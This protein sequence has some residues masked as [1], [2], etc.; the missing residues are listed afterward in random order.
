[1]ILRGFWQSE[2]GFTLVE[3]MTTITILGVLA[4]VAMSSWFGVVESR[5]VDSATNEVVSEL[6]RAHTS[7]TTRLDDWQVVLDLGTDNYQV[8]PA[9]GPLSSRSLV[10]EEMEEGEPPPVVLTGEITAVEFQADGEAT[11]T[12]TGNIQVAADDGS[13]CHEI[14]VNTVTSRIEVSTNAC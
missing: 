12:G 10:R 1:V 11:I 13:P 4:A 9:G 3:V 2:R 14:E 5:R 8:G 6:R 7:A